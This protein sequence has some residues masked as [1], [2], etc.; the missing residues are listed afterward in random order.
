M[1]FF[2][3]DALAVG[4]KGLVFVGQNILVYRRDENAPI[5][6]LL[7]DVPGGG[8]ERDETPF[9]TFKREV[10]EEFGLN[11]RKKDIVYAKRY[12][13]VFENGKFGWFAVAMLPAA[14]KS[15]IL[16]GDEGLGYSLITL[17]DFLK[18]ED[19][20]PIYQKRAKEYKESSEK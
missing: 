18:L 9:E 3:T 7:I 11:I 10:A 1:N 20:W 19:A 2:E 14:K 12:K 17:E 8:A 13:S 5:A 16:F 6:P 4:T 15:S